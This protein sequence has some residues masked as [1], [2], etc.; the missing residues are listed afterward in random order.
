M[1]GWSM[2]LAALALLAYANLSQAD[3]DADAAFRSVSYLNSSA[4]DE[5][6]A[7]HRQ[8]VVG[9]A[10]AGYLVLLVGGLGLSLAAFGPA[11]TRASRAS[12]PRSPLPDEAGTG[13]SAP[14]PSPMPTQH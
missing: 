9:Y 2:I 13:E 3:A 4:M 10:V 8:E 7:Q 5:A 12:R 11:L 14:A 6:L 1:R